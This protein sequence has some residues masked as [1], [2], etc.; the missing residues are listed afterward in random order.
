MTFE[1][2]ICLDLIEISSSFI[3][4]LLRVTTIRTPERIKIVLCPFEFTKSSRYQTYILGINVNHYKGLFFP[5]DSRRRISGQV[6][7][8][9]LSKR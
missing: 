6:S 7:Y 9:D 8:K 3:P 1:I 5:Y 2:E 4:I